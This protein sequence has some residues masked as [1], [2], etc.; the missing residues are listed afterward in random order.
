MLR[1]D[2]AAGQAIAR[3]E[4]ANG[5]LRERHR[6]LFRRH[7]AIRGGELHHIEGDLLWKRPGIVDRI[8]A[9]HDYQG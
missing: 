9:S 1:Q 6:C 7:V 8:I 4:D 2:E 5:E 3:F